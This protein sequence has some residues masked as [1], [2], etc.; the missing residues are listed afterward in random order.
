MNSLK[1]SLSELKNC[2]SSLINDLK[3]FIFKSFHTKSKEN[4]SE[5]FLNVKEFIGE[6]DLK[7]L[8]NCIIDINIPEELWIN[9]VATFINKYRVPKDWTDEDLANFKLKTKELA[10]K[11]SIIESTVGTNISIESK[12]C[13]NILNEFKKL[14]EIDKAVFLR[15]AVNI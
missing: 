15:N 8:L 11:F 5:R 7:V 4:L 9:R 12:D 13:K 10:F 2:T 6:T 14:S 3:S 1:I